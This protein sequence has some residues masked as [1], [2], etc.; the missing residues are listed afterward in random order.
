MTVD[1]EKEFSPQ[2]QHDIADLLKMCSEHKTDS[3]TVTM[4]YE[5]FEL[6]IEMTFSIRPKEGFKYE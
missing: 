2:F 6:D 4:D 3:L 5:P 1:K